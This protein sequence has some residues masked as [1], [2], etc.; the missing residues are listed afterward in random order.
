MTRSNESIVA[1]EP[2]ASSGEP[3]GG[4]LAPIG[5]ERDLCW[6]EQL[7]LANDAISTAKT[8]GTARVAPDL[9]TADNERIT[10]FERLDRRVERICHVCM[11]RGEAISVRASAHST[12][13]RLIVG[14][15]APASLIPPTDGQIVHG[16]LGSGRDPLRKGV[17]KC[18]KEQVDD[19]L[20]CLDVSAGNRR[21]RKRIDDGPARGDNLDRRK[22]PGRGRNITLDQRPEDIED[23]RNRDRFDRVERTGNLRCTPCKIDA[24][25][26]PR[27]LNPDGDP[28][29][30]RVFTVIV[31][32]VDCFI[33]AVG[34]RVDHAP[35]H[36]LA[37]LKKM[38]GVTCRLCPPIPL[39]DPEQSLLTY[40][41]CPEL[42][43]K[44]SLTLLT[45]TNIGQQKI[46]DITNQLSATNEA[47]RGNANPLLIYLSRRPHRSGGR[48][49][50]VGVM[51]TVCNIE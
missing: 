6:S 32:V 11:N 50:N 27:D 39:D 26:I 49:A 35:H 7:D 46:P 9:V 24:R 40:T 10:I 28:N 25:P 23:G 47:N 3:I 4:E 44:V 12:G 51:G 18:E 22:Q 48:A 21:R 42:S 38:T 5:E 8:P 41:Q 15:F 17:S 30:I 43:G 16:P 13:D 29:R 45:P 2:R 33:N 34:N 1:D 14:K 20:R 19:P 31:K 36:L 37:I